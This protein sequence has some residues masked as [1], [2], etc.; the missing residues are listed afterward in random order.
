MSEL[1]D[2]VARL[3]DALAAID[4]HPDPS[5]RV[6]L[7]RCLDALRRIHEEGVTRLASLALANPEAA[8]VALSDPL[9][10]NL[11]H[12]HGI[13]DAEEGVSVVEVLAGGGRGAG[14]SVQVR[15]D[16]GETVSFL[17]EASLRRMER[18]VAALED[19]PGPS[20]APRGRRDLG[21]LDDVAEDGAVA[22]RL[23]HGY[24]VLLV[25]TGGH[26]AAYR[27][28]CPGSLL[29]LHLGGLEGGALRCP[30][31]GCRFDPATGERLD[32]G[33]EGLQRLAL[34]AHEGRTEVELP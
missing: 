1:D 7:G 26:L 29:P 3:H 8:R 23:V 5:V 4:A 21:A 13:T 25:R 15:L 24:P 2:A 17:P 30:W 32:G 12:L 9:V 20:P 19:A 14:D 28:T 33:G 27:N 6:L 10:A 34:H 22:G 18:K 16:N 31:H 11:L